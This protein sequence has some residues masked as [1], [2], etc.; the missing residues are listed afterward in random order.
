MP[1]VPVLMVLYSNDAVEVR[2]SDGS[3]LQVAPCGSTFVHHESPGETIHPAHD[4]PYVCQ[5]LLLED[6]IVSLYAKIDEVAWT[7]NIEE[8][9]YEFLP[10]GSVRLVSEDEFASLVLSPHRSDFTVCFLCRVSSEYRKQN[11][12]CRKQIRKSK[13]DNQKF[14]PLRQKDGLQHGI[15]IIEN[16]FERE[17]NIEG[18]SDPSS[19]E[20]HELHRHLQDELSI[21]PISLASSQRSENSSP[22]DDRVQQADFHR[23]STPTFGEQRPKGQIGKQVM[24]NDDDLD[25]SYLGLERQNLSSEKK[26][27]SHEKSSSNSTIKSGQNSKENTFMNIS[28]QSSAHS[29]SDES[30]NFPSESGE[31]S[32]SRCLYSWITKHFS[33]DECPVAWSHPVNMAKTLLDDKAKF[34]NKA[35]KSSAHGNHLK[36]SAT[37]LHKIRKET[38]HMSHLPKPLYVTCPGQ[39]LHKQQS[40]K[41]VRLSATKVIEIFPGDGSVF[42]S[43]GLS[44]HFFRHLIPHPETNSLEERTYSLKALPPTPPTAIYSIEKLLKRANRFMVQVNQE[45]KILTSDFCCWKHEDNKVFEPLSTSLLEECSVPGYGRFTAFSSGHVRVVFEDRSSLD[46]MCDFTKRIDSCLEHSKDSDHIKQRSHVSHQHK[47]QHL[48]SRHDMEARQGL[49]KL[50]LPNGQYQ[51]VDIN[52]PGIY[53]KYTDAALEWADWVNSS[54]KERQ[55]FY[56]TRALEQNHSQMA[57]KEIQKIKCFNYVVENTMQVQDQARVPP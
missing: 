43:E 6:D 8:A 44:G 22:L 35:R 38:C 2:Y 16:K 9:Q 54:P 47:H 23:Y 26:S 42:V 49:C 40:D 29:C 20:S 18:R 36:S 13:G 12:K 11:N 53:R 27:N 21:S 31:E 15:D 50:L 19:P 10:D 28:Q 37:Y 52:Q 17:H 3:C 14:R 45:D 25:G 39:H 57:T 4:R 1:V 30:G 24:T 7:K 48:M 56:K 51:M 33:C 32:S 46:M 34:E 55:L 41:I 5:D